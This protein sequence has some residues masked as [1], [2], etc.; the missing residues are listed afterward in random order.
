MLYLQDSSQGSPVPP[1]H[2]HPQLCNSH[3]RH[4]SRNATNAKWGTKVPVRLV[5]VSSLNAWDL[6]RSAR[7]GCGSVLFSALRPRRSRHPPTP[8]AMCFAHVS[9]Y[10]LLLQ[11]SS[12]VSAIRDK[13]KNHLASQGMIKGHS[14][15]GSRNAVHLDTLRLSDY[16]D[17]D[18]P[19]HSGSGSSFS[20]SPQPRELSVE[21]DQPPYMGYS[22]MILP[23]SGRGLGSYGGFGDNIF[24]HGPLSHHTYQLS[25]ENPLSQPPRCHSPSELSAHSHMDGL[26][27]DVENSLYMSNPESEDPYLFLY[28]L[29][30]Y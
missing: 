25:F 8:S 10:L 6:V 17:V 27:L 24:H 19:P 28:D 21:S 26:M 15:S 30:Q 12:K 11:E 23:P 29:Y 1:L 3:T 16:K 13:I 5:F 9:F 7:T 22:N 18:V 14:G 20:G 2:I 4:L